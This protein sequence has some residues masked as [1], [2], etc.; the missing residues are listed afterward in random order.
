VQEL[1]KAA[2]RSHRAEGW[3]KVGAWALL[4]F[5]LVTFTLAVALLVLLQPGPALTTVSVIGGL[6]PWLLTAVLT[7]RARAA[8]R[9]R[10]HALDEAWLG[11]AESVLSASGQGATLAD[12]GRRMGGQGARVE[13]WLRGLGARDTIVTRVTDSGELAYLS[14]AAEATSDAVPGQHTGQAVVGDPPP[15]D[16]AARTRIAAH[17]GGSPAEQELASR[18]RAGP[19]P[20][21]PST[22]KG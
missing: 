4:G 13:D 5:G 7:R 2:W 15:V 18:P 1:L 6:L 9:A 19:R 21:S 22:R 20:H 17:D 12:L 16:R 10:A 11:A 3:C 14:R 8:G